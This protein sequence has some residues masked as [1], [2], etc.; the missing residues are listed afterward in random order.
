MHPEPR[1]DPDVQRLVSAGQALGGLLHRYIAVHD[2]IFKFSL[3]RSIPIPGI[4]Q[5]IDFQQQFE[6]LRFIEMDLQRILE[7]IGESPLARAG[8]GIRFLAYGAALSAAIAQL[9]EICGSLF[10]KADGRVPYSTSEYQQDL[11]EYQQRVA[12]YQQLGVDIN[13]L[14]GR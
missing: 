3:R 7:D 13:V 12:R 2:H 9:R 5:P 8:A 4:F 1:L 14:F 11:A 6:S 10:Q